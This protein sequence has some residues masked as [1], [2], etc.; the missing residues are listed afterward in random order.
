MMDETGQRGHFVIL[1]LSFSFDLFDDFD[2]ELANIALAVEQ[3]ELGGRLC[4]NA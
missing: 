2:A 4:S 1:L 3:P